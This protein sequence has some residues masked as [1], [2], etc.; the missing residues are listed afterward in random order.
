MVCGWLCV[1][2]AVV[3]PQSQP[4]TRARFAVRQRRWLEIICLFNA[5]CFAA[6]LIKSVAR[7][8]P[9]ALVYALCANSV[10][11]SVAPA[12]VVR[13]CFFHMQAARRSDGL[14]SVFVGR[15]SFRVSKH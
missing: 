4:L 14:E 2:V 5:A 1:C 6:V 12:V 3:V 11:Q 13:R 9:C 15:I 7:K 10:C 8:V